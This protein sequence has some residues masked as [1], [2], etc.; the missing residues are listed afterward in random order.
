MWRHVIKVCVFLVLA[1][2]SCSGGKKSTTQDQ[3][4]LSPE[5]GA[6]ALAYLRELAAAVDTNK[7]D[8]AAMA[9]AA[10]KVVASNMELLALLRS[11]AGTSSHAEWSEANAE[12][13]GALA[14][15]TAPVGAC[16]K[17][18]KAFADA[19]KPAAM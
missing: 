14:E 18:D 7:A 10:T 4:T 15:K 5:Q 11:R 13:L 9:T 2:T 8:C 1:A 19:M 16:M 17:A 6:S 12:E 3:A